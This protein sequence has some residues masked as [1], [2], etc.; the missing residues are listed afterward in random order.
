MDEHV[1]SRS[2]DLMNRCFDEC[3]CVGH[4][5]QLTD[6]WSAPVFSRAC[7]PICYRQIQPAPARLGTSETVFQATKIKCHLMH[8]FAQGRELVAEGCWQVASTL[9]KFEHSSCIFQA[10][11]ARKHP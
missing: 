3:E 1:W 10:I 9:P 6:I 4:R 2:E 5:K 7:R 11:Q 8:L